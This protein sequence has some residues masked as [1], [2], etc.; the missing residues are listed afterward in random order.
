MATLDRWTVKAGEALQTAA[1]QARDSGHPE[2]GGA[3][4]LQ[5]LLEQEGG[6][7]V[8]VLEKAEV[9]MGQLR[10]AVSA[11]VS[12]YGRVEGGSDPSLSRALRAVLKDA[13]K[14]ARDRKDEYISTEHLLLG[15]TEEK[16]D[17]GRALR[18]AGATRAAVAAAL[19]QVR[20]SHRVTDQNP[21]DKF[22]ALEKYGRDLTDLAREGKLDPVIGRDEEVRR[23]MKVLG[24]RTK[25]NPVLIGEPGVGKTAIVEGLA[26][27][28][29]RDRTSKRPL[30]GE[31]KVGRGVWPCKLS[32]RRGWRCVPRARG[33][34]GSSRSGGGRRAMGIGAGRMVRWAAGYGRVRQVGEARIGPA[35]ASG[36]P[37][38]GRRL[39]ELE[40]RDG[41]RSREVE[42]RG[43]VEV[44]FGL[45]RAPSGG[46]PGGPMRQVEVEEDALYGGGEGDEGDDPHLAAAGRAQEGQHLVDASQEL[47]PVHAARC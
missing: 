27:R 37:V 38:M 44:E 40:L 35:R 12:R 30:G 11:A 28:M 33:A 32:K 3:H 36:I 2:V 15:L 43:L 25:N 16:D 26:Q 46:H 47:G 8:P 6:I 5:A 22:Q 42:G 31:G 29:V 4:L 9:R 17:A 41:L 18:E 20:G 21:E 23:V 45:G 1:T 24:R 19:E 13:E 34:P 10:D 14:E 7:V 39:I